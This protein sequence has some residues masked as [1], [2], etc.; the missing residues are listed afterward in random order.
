MADTSLAETIL[1]MMRAELAG[2]EEMIALGVA[3]PG[4]AEHVDMIPALL[5][6]F[7]APKPPNLA[8]IQVLT[9]GERGRD[10]GSA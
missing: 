7:A 4:T 9:R 8:R 2:C 1:E 6:S 3:R 10:W 5:A